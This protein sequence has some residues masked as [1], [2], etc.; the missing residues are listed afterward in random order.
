VQIPVK[1]Q[2]EGHDFAEKLR[3]VLRLDPDVVMVGKSA[4]KIR[5][6]LRFKGA[7]TGHLVLSTFHGASASAALARMLD[8]VGVNPL[9]ASSMHLIM[10]QRLYGAWMTLLSKPYKPDEALKNNSKA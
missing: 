10:A 5:L 1:G 7:L 2:M 3:A 4:T 8:M 9:F 6:K